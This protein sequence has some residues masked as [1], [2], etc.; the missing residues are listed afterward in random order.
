M[1]VATDT[2]AL[3]VLLRQHRLLLESDPVLPSVVTAIAG[4]PL[5]GSWWG[6]P[7]G[8]RIFNASNALAD[9]PDVLT[10]K[11]VGGKVTYILRELWPAFLAVAASGDAWQLE[12]L[13][14]EARRFLA[15]VRQAGRMTAADL[16][17][18]DGRKPGPAITELEGRLLVH[19]ESVHTDS[20]R[21]ERVLQTWARWA[22]DHGVEAG[23]LTPAQGR[24][25]L[26]AAFDLLRG[27]ARTRV[28]L[29]WR[30]QATRQGPK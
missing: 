12:G 3:L 15:A 6:H 16:R 24:E 8:N 21:H 11:L 9:H 23:D 26:E 19:T 14:E 5:K 4:E 18:P 30:R 7:L 17:A 27:D 22:K 25:R 20:G 29:P 2:A 1:P 10:A 28:N 13:G